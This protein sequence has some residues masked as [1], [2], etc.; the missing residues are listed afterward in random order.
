[1]FHWDQHSPAQAGLL[2]YKLKKVQQSYVAFLVQAKGH[3][4]V[5]KIIV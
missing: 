2:L 3:V 5:T 4:E 1:M